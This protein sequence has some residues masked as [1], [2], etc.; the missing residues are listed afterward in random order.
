M[1]QKTK[2]LV[3]IKSGDYMLDM[4]KLVF[5]GIVLVLIMQIKGINNYLLLALGIITVLLFSILGIIFF[6]I[7]QKNKKKG[8]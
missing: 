3:L 5:G 7:S 1:K 2:E 8:A 6:H 4:S